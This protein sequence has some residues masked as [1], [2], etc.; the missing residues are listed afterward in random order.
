MYTHQH[1]EEVQYDLNKPRMAVYKN[2][3]RIHRKYCN[4]CNLKLA[5]RKGLQFYQNTIPRSDSLINTFLA[6]CIEKVVYMQTGE[7]LYCKVCQSP[8]LP[9]AVLTPNLHHGRQDLTYPE[10]RTSADHQSER[11][12]KCEETR[13][14]RYEETRRCYVDYR[15][16]GTLHSTVQKE[17]S[18]AKTS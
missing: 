12:A 6:M 5:Q 2:S 14:S 17:D 8:R 13:R 3:W 11:S 18:I 9:R 7:E 1:Q 16:Q 15:I 10:A 4:W